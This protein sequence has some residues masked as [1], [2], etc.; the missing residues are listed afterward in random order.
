MT[1]V[2]V[3]S[4]LIAGGL[5]SAAQAPQPFHR[6]LVFEPNQ[7]QA[8][9]QIKWLGQSS[10]YQV[11]LGGEGATIIIPD[12]TGLGAASKRLPGTPPPL[13]IP[14][15]A[16]RMKL[17]GNR[18]WN[19][20]SGAEP[21]GGVSNYVNNRDLK[22]SVNRVPQYGRVKVANVYEGID[23]IFYTNAGDLEYDFAVAP[24][25][26]PKQIQVVFE[27]TKE[28]RLD[29]KSGDLIVT[30]PDGSEL[31]QLKPKVYQQVGDKRVEIAGGYRLAGPQRA[32]F[33][34]AGYDRS[35]ALVIDPRLTIARSIGGNKDDQANAI[36]V[37]NNGNSFI[38]GFTISMNFPVTDKSSYENCKVFGTFGF[39]GGPTADIFVAEVAG[40]GSIPFVT[41]DGVGSGN[42]IAVDSTGIYIT[43]E[44]SPPDSDADVSTFPFD[45][46]NGEFFIQKLSIN[47]A[48]GYFTF[49]GGP[50]RDFGSGIALDSEHNAWAAGASYGGIAIG[51]SD[52]LIVK[53]APDG[54]KLFEIR[55]TSTGEDVAYGVAV[56][57]ADQPWI[58]GKTCGDG[59]PTSDGILH[60][61][62][63]CAV[64]VLQLVKSGIQTKLGMILGG[65]N[66]VDDVGVAIAANGSNAAYVTGYTRNALFPM[67]I[68]AWKGGKD[69]GG[70]DGFIT[71]VDAT[72]NV[73]RVVHSTFLEAQ[74]DTTPF[75]IA[76]D[77][78]GGV[79]VAG[80]TLSQSFPGAT[81]A[82]PNAPTIGFVSKFSADLSQLQYSVLLGRTLTGV[83]LRGPLPVFPPEAACLQC[84]QEVYVAGWE[85]SIFN[86]PISPH[87]AFM[88]KMVE[89]VLTSFVTSTS[90]QV[91]FR[92]FNISWG[93][94]SPVGG[95]ITFD[96]FVS[97]NGGPFTPFQTGTTAR[98]ATFIGQFGHTYGFFSIATDAAGNKEPMKSAPDVVV[99]IVDV[100]APVIT[101]QIT[102]T[103]GSN[104]WYRSAVTASWNISD[105][106]SGIASSTGCAPTNLT[107]DTA[108]VT[109]TCSASNAAG[110]A[111]S[112]PIS[113]KLDTTPPV[114]SGMPGAGCSLWPPNH[115]LVQVATVTAADALS[116]LVPGSLHLSV[117]SNEP[118][119]D[120]N[121][122]EIV[123]TPVGS[124]GFTVQLQADRL[125]S[126]NGRIYTFNATA[127]D[128]A[129]NSATVTATC[130]V[131]HDKGAN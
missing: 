78:R 54:K 92:N 20:I 23:L 61:L 66:G 26:D 48:P 19:E 59:F 27:G 86:D 113:I 37:D 47:G 10:S 29:P 52:V 46:N 101:P 110:L 106:E 72:T 44:I 84:V 82:G 111:T 18:P 16:V 42:G 100:T 38:T 17:G 36:A 119:S 6:P 89:D 103:L 122:P 131:P 33:T 130:T 115:K 58:T 51:A 104:G 22:H 11:L 49:A 90:P 65:D 3:L 102:G 125:G 128:N 107:A 62:N 8:P 91:N 31:R 81:S 116:G 74:G 39:C 98:S 67:T 40:D 80:A 77:N 97:D 14:Y 126:G 21:T 96:I 41:Y 1:R 43:G 69:F 121:D 64:F 118:S 63:N 9:A 109:L 15:R 45:N 55:Y 88:V 85:D 12:K 83:A 7:G 108:G 34:L 70:I 87:D 112:V 79:Y 129:G 60:K 13:H 68:G 2:C 105:P 120:P 30:L 5:L 32:A 75:A 76:N 127:M 50:D 94:S 28:M 117:T 25:A 4:A 57:P 53:V 56:D 99:K 124:G 95:A 35:Q 93:G 123:I 73:G 24:G 71:E 114:I